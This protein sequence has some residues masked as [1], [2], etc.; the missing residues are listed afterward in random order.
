MVEM[1]HTGRIQDI[2][3]AH[4]VMQEMR[5][6]NRIEEWANDFSSYKG[7]FTT[8]RFGF[9]KENVL[10]YLKKVEEA[11][12][13][14]AM[15]EAFLYI[16]NARSLYFMIMQCY[17]LNFPAL[18]RQKLPNLDVVNSAEQELNSYVDDI[19]LLDDAVRKQWPEV[20]FSRGIY[21]F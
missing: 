14:D 17:Y 10:S 16:V 15:K 11:K 21:Y 18:E 3:A 5:A 20:S 12:G 13:H 1:V 6:Q 19:S 2:A 9:D 7:E 4:Q 8:K